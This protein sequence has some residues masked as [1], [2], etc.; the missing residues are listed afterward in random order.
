MPTYVN[1]DLVLE[2]GSYLISKPTLIGSEGSITLSSRTTLI[3]APK[4]T[5]KV[6]GGLN[7]KGSTQNF[8]QITSQNIHDPG[9]GFIIQ[10][11]D[12]S[13]INIEFARFTSLQKPLTF[14]KNWSRSSVNLSNSI[15]KDLDY[16]GVIVEFQDVDNI[17]TK[18]QIP[19]QI[20]GNTF[21]NNAGSVLIANLSSESI[22]FDISSN[23]FSRNQ[24]IGKDLNGLFTTPLFLNYNGSY[25]GKLP[26]VKNNSICYNFGS[27]LLSDTVEFFPVFV[28]A[29]G[30]A[31]MLD[32][33]DNYLG[34]E[35][36][37]Q[38][39]QV[40]DQISSST[41]SPFIRI[42]RVQ[43]RPD[44]NL[45][46]HIY[47]V[48][49][50]GNRVD[51]PFYN[52]QI[53]KDIEQLDLVSNRQVNASS[54][55]KIQYAYLWDDT[56]RFNNFRYKLS[57]EN[58]RQ[59]TV[60]DIRDKIFK[61]YEHGF[62]VVDG[63][64]DA[65]GFDVPTVY[66]GIKDFITQNREFILS[67]PD[68]RAIPKS[69]DQIVVIPD[70][71]PGLDSD[72]LRKDKIR[73]ES[74]ESIV[75]DNE[76]GNDSIRVIKRQKYWDVGLQLASTI[77]FGDLAYTGVSFYL[78][79]ARPSLGVSLGF[80]PSKRLRFELSQ[81]SMVIN[82]DDR[83]SSVVGKNRGT[84]Y[85]RGLSFRT[86]IID[87][88]FVTEYQFWE[89]KTFKTLVPSI[90]TGVVGFYFKPMG[91]VG[92][93]FYDLRS[94]GTEGQTLEGGSGP[95]EK[96]SYG[97]P[98]GIKLSR[99]LNENTLIAISYTYN[100]IYT[101]YL[102]DVSTGLFP[103]EEA[104]KAANPDLEDIS[105]KLSNPNNLSGQRSTSA[106]HDGYAYWGFSIYKKF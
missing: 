45:N 104:L 6:A 90:Y 68:W 14:N 102:D 80:H 75:F 31:E 19:V 43:E 20:K 5:I 62:I 83:R 30:S 57:Q 91:Q 37:K 44:A 71:E 39:E 10:G 40:I 106:D 51:H 23:V 74:N 42:D 32:M 66:I 56:L 49:I 70:S 59:R 1:S 53:N 41:P 105:V 13:L 65:N 18:T 48:G 29:I 101:D 81:H 69:V 8:V 28:S 38:Y 4:A 63:L 92:G 93:Q 82:G 54:Q 11:V 47:K 27:L 73:E 7:I 15:F 58:N 67:Y 64:V 2:E 89:Y 86:T 87:L 99:H 22:H 85:D 79:N 34:F 95:Y 9:I 17:L 96:F 97:I 100:R 72:S 50:N 55:V 26:I 35:G 88:A 98:F 77:Y 103:E 46:G 78:P 21:S 36:Q 76:L 12:E 84:N 16:N 3:F 25:K 60:I 33:N 52:I 94:I 61:D 24:Y